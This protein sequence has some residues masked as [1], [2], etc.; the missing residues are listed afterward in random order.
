MR[1]N[2]GRGRGEPSSP[3]AHM[4]KLNSGVREAYFYD[5]YIKILNRTSQAICRKKLWKPKTQLAGPF[6][7][8]VYGVPRSTTANTILQSRS[9]L[10]TLCSFLDSSAN[11]LDVLQ[12]RYNRKLVLGQIFHGKVILAAWSSL[13]P[14]FS[15]E[16]DVHAT[17]LLSPSPGPLPIDV[18]RYCTQNRQTKT[19]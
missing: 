15:M 19:Q 16:F 12:Y 13:F 8:P 6:S 14:A 7:I 5:L 1:S 2:G 18:H 11:Q 9:W 3:V 17:T 4:D 10:S